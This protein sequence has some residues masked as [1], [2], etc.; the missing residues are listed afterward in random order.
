[1]SDQRLDL[2]EQRVDHIN[3]NVLRVDNKLDGIAETLM[4]LARIEERQMATTDR[5]RQGSET[6]ADHEERLR[7][8]EASVPENL[9]KRLASIETKM[10]GLVE[11]RGWVVAGVLG[12]LAMMLVALASFVLKSA[13]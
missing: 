1:M 5:L 8:V 3:S 12:G 7:R 13:P 2:L 4:S 6:F 9:H 11:S 10:P